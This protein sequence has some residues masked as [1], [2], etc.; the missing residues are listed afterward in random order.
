MSVVL[1]PPL[2]TSG[3]T[4]WTRNLWGEALAVGPRFIR[5]PRNGR[6][7]RPRS[8]TR[9]EDR[10]SYNLWCGPHIKVEA[11]FAEAEELPPG[12][13]LCGTCDGRAVG[14]GQDAWMVEGGPDLIFSPRRLTAPKRCPGSRTM[15]CEELAWNVGKC[16][17]CG[18]VTPM[19][20]SGGPYNSH[21]GMTNH[22]PGPDLIAGCP[23]HAWR[24]LRLV[25]GVVMCG[26]RIPR[27]VES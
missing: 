25:E 17:V 22:D 1:E 11:G 19:R 9:R 8:G 7:H 20:S 3:V 16:L 21:W 6:W 14:A 13:A 15:L 24:E 23:F 12:S 5:G 26:C 4:P 2:T 27:E 18:V 10:V